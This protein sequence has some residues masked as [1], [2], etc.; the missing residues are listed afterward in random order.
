MACTQLHDIVK[1]VYAFTHRRVAMSSQLC[2]S[3]IQLW[4]LSSS[5]PQTQSLDC[6]TLLC[7]S[8]LLARPTMPCIRLVYYE[9]G[10]Y[11]RH[12]H[13]MCQWC[14]SKFNELKNYRLLLAVIVWNY[15]VLNCV[16]IKFSTLTS[17]TKAISITL[18]LICSPSFSP[19]HLLT[20]L[21][22]PR[23]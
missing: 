8:Q 22:A 20:V 11:I 13:K 16:C 9:P 1:Y 7:M 18:S 23:Q 6:C 19:V 14:P 12:V 21:L 2:S 15:T 10:P 4:F 17:Q 5:V 3:I